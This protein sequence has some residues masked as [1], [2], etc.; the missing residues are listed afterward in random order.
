MGAIYKGVNAPVFGWKIDFV[1][2]REVEILWFELKTIEGQ[3]EVVGGG[4]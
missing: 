2:F 3:S 1:G 4:Q